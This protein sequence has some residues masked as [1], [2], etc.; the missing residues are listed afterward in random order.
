[1]HPYSLRNVLVATALACAAC[2]SPPGAD[3]NAN[4]QTEDN[5][6]AGSA[7]NTINQERFAIL[8]RLLPSI[9]RETA[10]R[11]AAA[12]GTKALGALK[13]T[14]CKGKRS[15]DARYPGVSLG[16]CDFVF[17]NGAAT[18]TL[19]GSV[20][21]S[22]VVPGMPDPEQAEDP[23]THKLALA[24]KKTVRD[25]AAS[26]V[27]VSS[28]VAPAVLAPF[29]ATDHAALEKFAKELVAK[30]EAAPFETEAGDCSDFGGIEPHEFAASE[31]VQRYCYTYLADR[32]H[33]EVLVQFQVD[34]GSVVGVRAVSYGG[35]D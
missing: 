6:S 34:G 30:Q 27:Y 23:T 35:Y 29:A 24:T 22:I 31:H 1:M 21:A 14:Q 26:N 13:S 19:T 25:A 5:L 20:S 17:A 2:A 28:G 15:A 3:A 11:F 12:S 32:Y 9:G 10:A 7:T 8:E 16:K 4:D 18:T 33:G